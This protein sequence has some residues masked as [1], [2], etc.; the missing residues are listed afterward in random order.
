MTSMKEMAQGIVFSSSR[1]Q[2]Y[3]EDGHSLGVGISRYLGED[4]VRECHRSPFRY[5]ARSIGILLQEMFLMNQVGDQWTNLRQAAAGSEQISF[6]L[7]SLLVFCFFFLKPE[8]LLITFYVLAFLQRVQDCVH[9][10]WPEG[11]ASSIVTPPCDLQSRSSG[12]F[13]LPTVLTTV[14]TES[15]PPL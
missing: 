1:Q 3:G 10:G 11:R 4:L 9:Q 13:L 7:S 6:I 14:T 8:Y 5:L 15:V 12:E 2:C